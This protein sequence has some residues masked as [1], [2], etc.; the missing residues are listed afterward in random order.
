MKFDVIMNILEI[1]VML[2][3]FMLSA[4]LDIQNHVYV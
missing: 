1:I 3:I 2:F 4:N